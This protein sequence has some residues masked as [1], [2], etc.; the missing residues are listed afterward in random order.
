MRLA[1]VGSECVPY[2]S[3]G[4]L[5][6]VVGGLSAALA[7][8]GHEVTV[9]LPYYRAVRERFREKAQVL[10]R[11]VT[12]PF[13]HYNRYVAVVDGGVLEGVKFLFIDCPEL[14]DRNGLYG[15]EGGEYRD[16][17]ER[18]G[19][20]CRA[21]LE[22]S[23]QLDIPEV[24]HVHD[25]QA[26]MLPV[27]LGTVY[28]TDPALRRVATVQTLHNAGYQGVF[29]AETT[30]R[31]LLPWE[32]FSEHGVEHYGRFNFLKGGLMYGDKLTTVSRRYAEEIQTPEYGE[33]LDGVFRWRAGDLRGILNGADQGH[34]DPER[35]PNLAAHFSTHDLAGKAECRADLLHAFGLDGVPE[36]T[37]VIGMVSRL[38]HQ[39]GLDLLMQAEEDLAGRDI[40]MVILGTGEPY[41]EKR[42][43]EWAGRR[44]DR[45]AVRLAF[46][47]AMAH[48][49]TAGSEMV[50]MPSLYEPCGLNQ[51]YAMRYGTVPV[52]RATGGL[53]DTVHEWDAANKSGTGFKFKEFTSAAM[54]E[55][56]DRALAVRQ[57]RDAWAELMRNGMAQ[58]FGWERPAEE[59]A[60]VYEEALR[61]KASPER[62]GR[63]VEV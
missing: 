55:A 22:V 53:E 4:G 63:A 48:K 23:K 20:F 30:Q 52:V 58:E 24:F 42:L 45:I 35:D 40:A 27:Y 47:E 21:V 7:R 59:Y 9:Y 6:E 1:M 18:F 43:T 15:D 31:L 13:E 54:V 11:S 51:I 34:W 26:A 44:S 8:A 28:A 32:I 60:A 25:W 33:S 41:Y 3:T 29:P 56:V 49:V 57:D 39:K 46:D 16:N 12:V 5:G 37:A 38:T 2:V 50:L 10:V 62:A 14:F 19:L 61:G 17:W 36:S